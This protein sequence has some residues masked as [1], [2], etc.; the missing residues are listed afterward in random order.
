MFRKPTNKD[1]FI[2]YLSA[3]DKRT[4]SGVVIGFFLR[5]LRIC[6]PEYLGEEIQYITNAFTKLGYPKGLLASLLAKAK[7]I[8]RRNGNYEKNNTRYLVVPFSNFAITLGKALGPTGM[9]IVSDSGKRIGDLVTHKRT[10]SG[11]EGSI[12]YKI[13]CSGCEK[14]YYGETYRGLTKR[15]R[16][17]RADVKHHRNTSALVNH[18]AEEDHLPKWDHAE[19]LGSNLS[20]K[21]RK[22]M[23]ALYI[24]TNENINQRTG[25][26]KWTT[27]AAAVARA[28]TTASRKTIHHINRHDPG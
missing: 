18:I 3:H 24:A 11:G 14:A 19:V 5:A 23:E 27:Y 7:I 26:M 21:N 25:D 16:E 4:K 6:S 10:G 9:T 12:V 20:K 13:P 28:D 2:H 15:L 1:D 22:M 17:H 8:S